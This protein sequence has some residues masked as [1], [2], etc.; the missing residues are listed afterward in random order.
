MNKIQTVLNEI[1]K[2]T[3]GSRTNYMLSL[4]SN[5]NLKDF[6][7]YVR[8]LASRKY[9]KLPNFNSSF[10]YVC[11]VYLKVNKI[12]YAIYTIGP[13]NRRHK[14]VFQNKQ[15]MYFLLDTKQHGAS[16][17]FNDISLYLNGHQTLI[18]SLRSL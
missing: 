17:H 1:D 11:S 6:W 18:T 16:K 2:Y 3:L 14:L 7:A 12:T 10:G 8:F 4:S 9:I 15:Y 13:P 5:G